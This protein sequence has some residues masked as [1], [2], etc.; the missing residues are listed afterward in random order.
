M[1]AS[2][3]NEL[4]ESYKQVHSM[5]TVEDMDLP[6]HV[7]HFCKHNPKD[8]R[9]VL[10]D[11]LMQTANEADEMS[12]KQ[13]LSLM[14]AHLK[15]APSGKVHEVYLRCVAT[16]A[17]PRLSPIL[18]YYMAHTPGG[19]QVPS[20]SPNVAPE[21]PYFSGIKCRHPDDDDTDPEPLTEPPANYTPENEEDFWN[22][23]PNSQYWEPK[24]IEGI[25]H[26][27]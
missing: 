4:R 27:P 5:T 25:E 19:W 1:Q 13:I 8:S 23:K 15:L 9:L 7:L 3:I 12:D 11:L 24:W 2:K 21:P 16:M 6:K 20:A 14:Q 17:K 18:P 22:P 10:N 26:I